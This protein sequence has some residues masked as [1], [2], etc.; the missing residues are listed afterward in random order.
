MQV[1]NRLLVSSREIEEHCESLGEVI[2]GIEKE[3][4]SHKEVSHAVYLYSCVADRNAFFSRHPSVC[5][6]IWMLVA[7]LGVVVRTYMYVYGSAFCMHTGL[8][9]HCTYIPCTVT[10][11]HM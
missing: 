4:G 6:Q 2:E 1:V 11:R 3:L 7:G 10:V 9:K 5:T 8:F